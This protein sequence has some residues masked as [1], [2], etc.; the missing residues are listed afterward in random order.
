MVAVSSSLARAT[1]RLTRL[2]SFVAMAM[3]LLG[4]CAPAA[5]APAKPAQSAAPPAGAAASP[6]PASAAGPAAS[7]GAA[8]SAAPAASADKQ[9]L[10]LI[11][12]NMPRSLDPVNIDAQRIIENGLPGVFVVIG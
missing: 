7:P 8:A 5:P 11:T 4:G 2:L 9:V 1:G 3:L 10:R 6:A 12:A